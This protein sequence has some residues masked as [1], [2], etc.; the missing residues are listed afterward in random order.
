MPRY[1]VEIEVVFLFVDIEVEGDSL[2]VLVGFLASPPAALLAHLFVGN[3]ALVVDFLPFGGDVVIAFQHLP[4]DIVAGR[5]VCLGGDAA[6][7]VGTHHHAEAV[8][9]TRTPDVVRSIDKKLSI[10]LVFR[11]GD[12]MHAD[13][14]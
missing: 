10:V 13:A 2:H 5:S 9:L 7:L 4:E 14:S 1:I 8:F 6:R 3:G 11:I 12:G